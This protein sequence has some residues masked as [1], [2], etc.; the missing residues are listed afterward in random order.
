MF[1]FH[2]NSD[3]QEL[4]QFI[5]SAIHNSHYFPIFYMN[6]PPD[7]NVTSV[8]VLICDLFTGATVP[9]DLNEINETL[10]IW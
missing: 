10:K 9:V 6:S 7:C 2:L 8:P 1:L 4:L 5:A 3:F